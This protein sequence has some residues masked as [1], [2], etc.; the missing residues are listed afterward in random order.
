MERY[1]YFEDGKWRVR[2][3]ETEHSGPW[4]D[5]LAAYEDTGLEPEEIKDILERYLGFRSAIFDETG[6][7][8]VSWM[9]VSKLA[10]ADKEGLA[11]ILP[12]KVGDM[13]YTESPIRGMV[14]SFKAPDL[15][16]IIE[17]ISEFGKTV[18]LNR[19]EAEAAIGGGGD[20]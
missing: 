6:Q 15:A 14:T 16:W 10:R 19:A 2:V 5:R 11:V 3:G 4:V 9:R 8:M 1:T 12:C 13:L 7:P 18:F 20:G 17:N